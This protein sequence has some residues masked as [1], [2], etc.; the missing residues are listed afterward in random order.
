M[1]T[2]ESPTSVP[3]ALGL[4]LRALSQ[5]EQRW[6]GA[7]V[8]KFEAEGDPPSALAEWIESEFD[9]LDERINDL[10]DGD[11]LGQIALSDEDQALQLL[12]E[13]YGN[14][15]D[16][17]DWTRHHG[18]PE[19]LER[20]VVAAMLLDAWFAPAIGGIH[21]IP[22]AAHQRVRMD[23]ELDGLILLPDHLGT[24]YPLAPGRDAEM[25]R[26]GLL[27]RYLEHVAYVPAELDRCV[28]DSVSVPGLPIAVRVARWAPELLAHRQA[29]PVERIM[30]A[31][32]AEVGSDVGLLPS[33]CRQ[34][35]GMVLHYPRERFAAV[36]GQAIAARADVLLLP[37][38][39]VREADLELLG[40][41]IFECVGAH[42]DE[43][44]EPPQL[45][46]VFAGVLTDCQNPPDCHRNFAV[47]FDSQGNQ[48]PIR[49]LKLSHW[50]L[51]KDEQD[52]FGVTYHHESVGPLNDPIFENSEPAA[53]I[54][55]CDLPRVGR[56]VTLICADMS[57][58]N[59]G[60]WL[61]MNADLG[62]IHAPIMDKSICWQNSDEKG[63]NRPWIVRRAHRA[64]VLSRGHVVTTNSMALTHWVNGANG[65]QAA[66]GASDVYPQYAASGI[67]LALAVDGKG[68]VRYQ[69]L[70]ARLSE[71]DVA[72][73]YDLAID[74]WPAYPL[75]PGSGS[76]GGTTP[77]TA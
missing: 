65:R 53:E 48:A 37:E 55:I 1:V 35:Y 29:D 24:I 61:F 12:K 67:G 10:V 27:A 2:M 6:H 40:D 66:S 69:H 32:L 42:Y 75:L 28:P 64:A 39:S 13:R 15:A 56:C 18:Q 20:V 77:P 31:P 46:F 17:T 30:V 43:H 54:L 51:R 41:T 52:R 34:Y 73:S 9:A 21:G 63:H 44:G 25:P 76:T 38:M 45:S 50:N 62:W 74:T 33:A 8:P 58:D 4:L 14:I 60:D 16:L 47:I 22:S 57:Q 70:L 23:F 19:D 11:L 36:I 26:L 5:W 49:Q 7:M 3:E 68:Q 71:S 72:L 59:P